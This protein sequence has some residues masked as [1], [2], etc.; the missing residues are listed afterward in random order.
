[1]PN[2]DRQEQQKW[3]HAN[4]A[5]ESKRA[6]EARRMCVVSAITFLSIALIAFH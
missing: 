5:W 2:L 1:M 6:K 4:D 3:I